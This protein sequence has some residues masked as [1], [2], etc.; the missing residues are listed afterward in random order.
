MAA[1]F[2]S[3]LPSPHKRFLT[4]TPLQ[5]QIDELSVA[6]ARSHLNSKAYG[7]FTAKAGL[8]QTLDKKF[9]VTHMKGSAPRF[10]GARRICI[11]RILRNVRSLSISWDVIAESLSNSARMV[12][13]M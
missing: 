12:M 11:D 2:N 9:P 8:G 5:K 4:S 6:P 13:E 10:N 1:L 7:Q 3:V